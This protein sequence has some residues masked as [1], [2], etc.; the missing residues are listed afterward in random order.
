M[1][2]RRLVFLWVAGVMG[3]G[4]AAAAEGP[5]ERLAGALR[6][7][8]L[9][10]ED[11]ADFDAAPFLAMHDYLGA[12]FPRT[13]AALGRERVANYSLLYTWTGSDPSLPPILLT[14]HID[15]VPVVP[16]TAEDWVHPP[17]GGVVAD[18]FVW[19]RG[20]LDDKVGVLA[21][22]EAVERL[23]SEGFVPERTVHLAFGHD[24]EVG[25]P[26]GAGSITRLLAERGVQHWFSLD[27][28]MAI[29]EGTAGI[30]RPVAMVGV[31]EKGFLTLRLT[32]R[33][34]GGH[35]SVPPPNGAIPRL[36]RALVRLD[37]TPLPARFGA[38]AGDLFDALAPYLP[39]TQAFLI[40]QRWAFGPILEAVLSDDPAMNAMLR[41][42]TALT[43]LE[44][45]VKA[46][47]LPTS[48]TATANFRL[49]P[50]D[51]VDFVVEEVR[52]II[53]DPDIE[54]EITTA[55]EA[56]TVSSSDSDAF[57]AI[58]SAVR[59]I[60]PDIVVAPALV[61]GGT[62]TKHYG[63]VSDDSYRFTPFRL[64]A[65]DVGRIHGT[66]ERVAVDDYGDM[67]TFYESL[68]EGA[69]GKR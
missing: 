63:E 25:G 3:F 14:S 40:E 5:V 17:F 38:V 53:D 58:A 44:G 69:A 59:A 35:S 42:T 26:N 68:L 37:E 15:V 45:G 62:D 46:N 23:L 56:S 66:N 16:G 67:I 47:V 9:S 11:P 21:T 61:V 51:S 7:E 31:A 10:H 22:L 19:G 43:I 8:T 18:G 54:I 64:G 50:G 65:A 27:E 28:G 1:I 2:A 24:E 13:H 55:R 20:A 52:R 34:T 60:E 57:A 49:V 29:L 36:A 41:T 12:A 6:F 39:A 33:A 30:D 32:A 48:A 4:Q